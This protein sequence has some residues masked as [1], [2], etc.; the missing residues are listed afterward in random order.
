MVKSTHKLAD[1][2]SCESHIGNFMFFTFFKPAKAKGDVG[3]ATK[4]LNCKIMNIRDL[5]YRM[6]TD[7]E[8]RL[9]T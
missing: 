6:I 4:T 8:N 9:F 1:M 2:T 3:Q 7:N 5:I